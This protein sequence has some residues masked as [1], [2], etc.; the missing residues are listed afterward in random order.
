MPVPGY[1]QV[2]DVSQ[3][4]RRWRR[5]ALA[6]KLK[7][8]EYATEAGFPLVSLTNRRV[9]E[10][11]DALYFSAGIHGDEPG[12]TEGLLRWAER[13]V[14]LLQRV[15]VL[16]FPCL[17]PWGLVNNSRF[18]HA[19]RDLNRTYHLRSTP[20][21][22]AHIREIGDR[23]FAAA[24]T[25]HEDYDAD[26]VYIYE[27]A[28]ARPYVGEK[29]IVATSPFIRPDVRKSIEGRRARNGLIRRRV[30]P[31]LMPEWPETFFLHFGHARR[32]FTIETP[33][34]HHIEDRVRAQVAA[35]DCGVRLSL[36]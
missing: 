18:D 30:T 6:A 17:N 23:T 15:P 21:T 29:M 35:I 34:E 22:A 7:W 32:T 28:A 19:G 10:S 1:P 20:A 3:L 16:I 9:H 12:A 13:E 4:L 5:V 14:D 24:F 11:P 33:S 31:D 8:H 36:G 25:L 2:H 27:V 26:G